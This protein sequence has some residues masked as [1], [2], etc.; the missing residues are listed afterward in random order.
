MNTTLSMLSICNNIT[1]MRLIY[2]IRSIINLVLFVIPIILIVMI[3]ID[4]TKN[5]LSGEEKEIKKNLKTI[6]NRIIYCLLL[7]FVPTIVDVVM[8]VVNDSGNFNIDYKTCFYVTLEDINN[9]EQDEKAKCAGEYKWDEQLNKCI[10]KT[11]NTETNNTSIVNKTPVTSNPNQNSSN[12]SYT[13][14]KNLTYYNQGVGKW[15]D[16]KYCSGDKLIRNSGCGAVALAMITSNYS[17]SKYDPEYIGK[18]ICDHGHTGGG[19]PYKFFTMQSMLDEFDLKVETLFTATGKN[20][21]PNKGNALLTAVQSGKG[22][23]LHIPG[24]YVV[25]GPNEK[26]SNNEVYYYDVGKRAVN[27]CYTPQELFNKT[28]NYKNRCSGNN[29]C[30]WK[31]AFAYDKK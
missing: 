17:N 15:K 27:G 30:G 1:I 9:A 7:F 29:N 22:I 8:G 10:Q 19:T 3:M 24:H 11:T 2:F 28:Y 26:C 6:M 12:N 4:L 31:I 14:I 13:S 16:A 23:I 25:I 20:Y 5:V 21:D 18:W